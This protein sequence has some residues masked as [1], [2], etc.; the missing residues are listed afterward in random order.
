MDQTVHGDP[1]LGL[2]KIEVFSNEQGGGPEFVGMTIE[3]DLHDEV[4]AV[5][6]WG[7]I[8]I[9]LLAMTLG[10]IMLARRRGVTTAT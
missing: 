1:D 7:L 2:V 10:T 9:T 3:V 4:P 5:S 6:E 8:V